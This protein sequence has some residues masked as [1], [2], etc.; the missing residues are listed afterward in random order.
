MVSSAIWQ[1]ETMRLNTRLVYVYDHDYGSLGWKL[2]RTSSMNVSNDAR[3]LTHDILE[4]HP[5]DKGTW[6]EELSAYGAI[7]VY[8]INLSDIYVPALRT[9]EA[10]V[11][12]LAEELAYFVS[13]AWENNNSFVFKMCASKPYY[14]IHPH[15]K[16]LA[17][18]ASK[19][20]T[21]P[22]RFNRH[23]SSQYLSI[24]L[25]NWLKQGHRRASKIVK[26]SG[27]QAAEIWQTIHDQIHNELFRIPM[28]L[29]EGAE[30]SVQIDFDRCWCEVVPINCKRIFQ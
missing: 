2:K 4:H 25:Q 7:V 12:R 14:P 23:I 18:E 16:L 19:S 27:Y 5:R 21:T 1:A 10:K 13:L 28:D 6:Y 11:L 17:D 15:I 24:F 29:F 9:E 22:D 20:I 8:K 30:I 3:T 26:E